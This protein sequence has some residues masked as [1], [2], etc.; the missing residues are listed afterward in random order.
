MRGWKHNTPVLNVYTVGSLINHTYKAHIVNHTDMPK[1]KKSRL[2]RALPCSWLTLFL[3]HV[4]LP[5]IHVDLS[6]GVR[7]MGSQLYTG[8]ECGARRFV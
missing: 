7:V 3:S 2:Q 6:K 8:G 1:Q 4:S 5:L